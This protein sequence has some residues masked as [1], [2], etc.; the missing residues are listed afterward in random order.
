MGAGLF[1]KIIDSSVGAFHY[2]IDSATQISKDNNYFYLVLN[3]SL[4]CWVLEILLPWRKEQKLFRKDFW[5]DAFYMLFN[6]FLF[7]IVGYAALSDIAVNLFNEL[8][9]SLNLENI[10]ALKLYDSPAWL[11]Y[12]V[13]FVVAD[14]IHWNVHRLLHRVPFLWKFHKV[15][16]SV[17]EMGFAA[18][19]RFHWM[20]NVLYKSI[21]Y[22]PLAMIGF[23]LD[24]FF[25]MHIVTISIG[26]LNHSNLNLNYGPFK[27]LLNNP[28]MHIWHHAKHL[29]KG[30]YG[31]NFGISLS[32][33]DYLFKTAYLPSDGKDIELGFED[34]EKYPDSFVKQSL[35]PFK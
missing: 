13:M 26:H 3:I 25:L 30:R 9:A 1:H 14:F 21:Q 4:A 17:K 23:G 18:H 32:V 35:D 28:K 27:Y 16:H 33:W 19:L 12:T 11:Q 20:E 8:L 29:P 15:H 6:L 5:L 24:D 22:I 10:V 7:Y 2:F 34:D 31:V